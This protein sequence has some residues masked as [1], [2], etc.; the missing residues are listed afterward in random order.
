[1]ISV[2]SKRVRGIFFTDQIFYP[3]GTLLYWHNFAWFNILIWLPLQALLNEATAYSLIFLGIIASFLTD[4]RRIAGSRS[5]KF[6][7]SLIC[8]LYNRCLLALFAQIMAAQSY[9]NRLDF[10]P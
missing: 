8:S 1:M 3:G 9:F 4:L 6:A 5:N 10:T 2:P 7:T